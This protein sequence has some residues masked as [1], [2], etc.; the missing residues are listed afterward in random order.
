MSK[1]RA[2]NTVKVRFGNVVAAAS[3]MAIP[4]SPTA[5]LS[6]R[7][8]AM[9]DVFEEYRIVELQ[10]RFRAFANTSAMAYYPGVT[11]NTPTTVAQV[12]EVVESVAFITANE[13]CPTSWVQVPKGILRGY[14]DWYKTVP[15]TTDA[16][17]EIQGNVLGVGSSTA[18]IE[19]RGLCEFR[20]SAV[21]A[22]TPEARAVA[23]LR[24]KKRLMAILN[25]DTAG[26][27]TKFKA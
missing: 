16:A 4:I 27:L 13:T 20:A 24:E 23:M 25:C 3:P 6:A 19:I 26:L 11:D 21:A 10:Y 22:N 7:L 9:A 18:Q 1:N 15:G 17:Q 12:Q 8:T 2:N 14:Q 5:T